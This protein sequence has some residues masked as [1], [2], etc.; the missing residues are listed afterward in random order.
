MH[1]AKIVSMA[2]L[3]MFLFACGDSNSGDFSNSPQGDLPKEPGKIDT[4]VPMIGNRLR[5][6]IPRFG[7]AKALPKIHT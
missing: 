5:E 4:I 2:A 6:I 7:R 1:F 3:P